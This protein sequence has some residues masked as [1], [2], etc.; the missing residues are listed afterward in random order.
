L[1]RNLL[2]FV[3]AAE[4]RLA[5]LRTA[6]RQHLAWKSILEDHL[7]E[8][9]ELT[10]SDQAQANSKL[11]ETGET[12]THRIGETYVHVLVPE[13]TAG[14]REIRWHQTKPTGAGSLAERI[15]RKLESEERLITS[16][17]GTRV[18]MDLDRIPLWSERGDITVEALWKAYCQF[19]YLPRLAGF[20]V[21]VGAIGDGVSKLN[22]QADSFA[23]ADGHD[24]ARYLG[25]A[26][27]Q[28]VLA[29]PGGYVIRPDVATVQINAEATAAGS[30]E[31]VADEKPAGGGSDT[32]GDGTS[33][34]KDMPGESLPT[35]FY[36]QFSLDPVRA[37]RH[38]EDILR[39]IADH[40][41]Q[42]DSG[43]VTLTLELNAKSSGFDDRTRRVV[44][45]NATQLGA[46]A[47]EFE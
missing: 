8:K 46:R 16:Y 11:S 44:G 41:A 45:E 1:N 28:H 31:G 40:L 15:A 19:P 43:E 2:V 42:A 17:G 21:L 36:A 34:G 7:H 12:V 33:G 10:K 23:Y 30:G 22:W 37:I 18:R 24:G 29:R 39:N 13:Q 32:K 6:A 20:D 27:G 47:Q 25:L 35:T 14:T 3:A 38:L 26:T 9:I 4:A 5:E